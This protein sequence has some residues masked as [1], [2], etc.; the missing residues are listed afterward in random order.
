MTQFNG[1][2]DNL[3]AITVFVRVAEC[4]SFSSAARRLNMTAS[5]VSKAISR[6]EEHLGIRLLSRSTRNVTLSAEG[7]EY[8]ER[9]R[10][11]FNELEDANAALLAAQG[12]PS[13]PL[14]IQVPRGLGRKVI[15]PALPGFLERYPDLSVEVILDARPLN[16]TEEAIDVSLRFGEPPDSGMIMR[17]LCKVHYVLCCSPEYAAE[18][19]TPKTIADL[20]AHTCLMYRKPRD[21]TSREWSLTDGDDIA[22]FRPKGRILVDDIHALVDLVL[23]GAGIAHVP[24]FMVADL[25]A[26]GK[27]VM[28]MPEAAWE[29]PRIYALYPHRVLPPRV[30]V[31]LDFLYEILPIE[32]QWYRD[33]GA[34]IPVSKKPRVEQANDQGGEEPPQIEAAE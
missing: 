7:A 10:R 33:I 13:G 12:T 8:F 5:G 9:C 23:A 18:H 11:A 20:D 17:R 14:K 24:D 4:K 32:P 29:A 25:V 22:I 1:G 28:L 31:L 26:S 6:L 21:V 34:R 15:L 19:G 2:L 3:R 16:L 30:R 27:V